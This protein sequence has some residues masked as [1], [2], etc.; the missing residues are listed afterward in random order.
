[1]RLCHK[2]LAPRTTMWGKTQ[3][4][5]TLSQS[6]TRRVDLKCEEVWK[7]HNQFISL[8]FCFLSM[9]RSDVWQISLNKSQRARS[10]SKYKIKLVSTKKLLCRLIGYFFSFLGIKF[11]AFLSIKL[12]HRLQLLVK[13][14]YLLPMGRSCWENRLGHREWNTYHRAWQGAVLLST[15]MVKSVVNNNVPT[16]LILGHV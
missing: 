12:W 4:T 2:L 1:M 6:V 13:Y 15:L 9:H 3:A 5:M 10:F 16:R 7:Y 11:Y 14:R 8:V